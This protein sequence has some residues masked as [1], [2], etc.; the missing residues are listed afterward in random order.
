MGDGCV[1][2]LAAQPQTLLSP[3]GSP[4]HTQPCPD[5]CLQGVASRVN[6][7]ALRNLSA[8]LEEDDDDAGLDLYHNQEQDDSVVSSR[9]QQQPLPALLQNHQQ[10]PTPPPQHQQQPGL[11]GHE[12]QQQQQQVL[13]QDPGLLAVSRS[14]STHGPVDPDPSGCSGHSQL[15]LQ[16]GL[17]GDRLAV[18]PHAMNAG[19]DPNP[20]PGPGSSMQ[21][22]QVAAHSADL[23]DGSRPGSIGLDGSRPGSTGQCRMQASGGAEGSD[24]ARPPRDLQQQSVGPERSEPPPLQDPHQPHASGCMTSHLLGRPATHSSSSN[25]SGRLPA[26]QQ[27]QHGRED[28]GAHAAASLGWVQ[29]QEQVQGPLQG[30]AQAGLLRLPAENPPAPITYGPSLQEV[31]PRPQPSLSAHHQNCGVSQPPQPPNCHQPPACHD[32]LPSQP[33]H[34][35]CSSH[36]HGSIGGPAHSRQQQADCGHSWQQQQAGCGQAASAAAAAGAGEGVGATHSP[37]STQ[38]EERELPPPALAPADSALS[39]SNS[40]QLEARSRPRQG[41]GG[42]GQREAPRGG[43][44]TSVAEAMSAQ[45]PPAV[46]QPHGMMLPQP[47]YQHHALHLGQ[48]Q[49]SWEQQQQHYLYPPAPPPPLPPHF[50]GAAEGSTLPYCHQVPPMPGWLNQQQQAAGSAGE[51]GG[52]VLCPRTRYGLC[53]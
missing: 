24:P 22:R 30:Q 23:Q 15:P 31:Q 4:Q 26:T 9:Q 17:S 16:G 7:E 41:G 53:L 8:L 27:Q 18:A 29:G 45:V 13:I 49:T 25:M 34:S 28:S 48:P 10:Q 50:G 52:G 12:G 51:G 20:L 38:L 14:Q 5:P 42:V 39:A 19:P 35:C 6:I 32:G 46:T 47:A 11:S 1:A 33:E 2:A 40:D 37:P 44:A 21:D 36:A 3:S 43:R